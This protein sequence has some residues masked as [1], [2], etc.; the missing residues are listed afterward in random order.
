MKYL[1]VFSYVG[2]L[3]MVLICGNIIDCLLS[4]NIELKWNFFNVVMQ[5]AG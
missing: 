5:N 3:F 2:F 4:Y 1:V